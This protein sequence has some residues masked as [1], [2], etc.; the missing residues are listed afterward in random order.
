MAFRNSRLALI[1]TALGAAAL[2]AVACT[3]NGETGNAMSEERVREL[4]RSHLIENPEIIAEAIN[5][6]QMRQMEQEL[7]SLQI[8]TAPLIE[9]EYDN[10]Y[11]DE[12]AP[13]IGP[14]DA[15][16]QIVEF[17]DY[18]CSACN[19]AAPWLRQLID[20]HGDQVRVIFKESPIF[21]DRIPTSEF[22]ARAGIAAHRMGAYDAF[23]FAMMETGSL[24]DD[25]DVLRIAEEV[26]LD[27]EELQ[28]LASE[29]ELGE[30][31]EQTQALMD[32][33]GA[34]GTP[35]FIVNGTLYPGTYFEEIERQIAD[36]LEAS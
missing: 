31:V 3:P 8:A 9:A 14:K 17:F 15:P 21:A 5:A 25:S 26:G 33:I 10:L 16:I 23:H 27:T 2:A 32:R 28:R 12:R 24:Y 13:S 29:V 4:V 30:Q 19:A 22:A 7:V 6:L 18:N 20:T 36:I 35:T 34:T 11:G 1:G